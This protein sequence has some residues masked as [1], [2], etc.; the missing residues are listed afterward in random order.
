MAELVK[1]AELRMSTFSSDSTTIASDH[2][3]R[4]QSIDA[5][6]SLLEV[7]LLSALKALHNEPK[8]HFP[9]VNSLGTQIIAFE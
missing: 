9:I 1:K 4:Q 7:E 3:Y 6:S 2:Q 8:P 5:T